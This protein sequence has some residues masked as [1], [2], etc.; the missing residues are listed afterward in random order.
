MSVYR[1]K[2]LVSVVKFTWIWK[3]ILEGISEEKFKKV[4]SKYNERLEEHDR[5]EYVKGER[6]S[7]DNKWSFGTILPLRDGH[8]SIIILFPFN[9]NDP[10]AQ[11]GIYTSFKVPE[12]EVL[13][14]A[15]KLYQCI[16]EV[17]MDWPEK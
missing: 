6:I 5:A 1:F 11:V 12:K 10:N 15:S 4:L 7:L 2:Y 14:S 13:Q 16:G 8:M 3:Q 9:A 17:F